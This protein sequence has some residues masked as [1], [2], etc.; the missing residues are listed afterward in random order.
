MYM[1]TDNLS[2]ESYEGII[3]ESE[4]FTHDLTLHYGV[5]SYECENETEYIDKAES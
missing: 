2:K 3:M 4:K 5:L 1:D